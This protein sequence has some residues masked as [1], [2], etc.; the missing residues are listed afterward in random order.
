MHMQEGS[1]PC[2]E[3][4]GWRNEACMA[5]CPSGVWTSDQ[6]EWQERALG[7]VW[8]G[9]EMG[10]KDA[11]FWPGA[12]PY[13]VWP[14]ISSLN[15]PRQTACSQHEALQRLL[16]AGSR[17]PGRPLTAGTWHSELRHWQLTD[18]RKWDTAACIRDDN[19]AIYS[20]RSRRY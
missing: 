18:G 2:L 5:R 20:I 1:E 8:T 14:V 16:A 6:A 19:K 17:Q 11:L 13:P 15:R 10:H 4:A 9:L 7:L 12:L 3:S